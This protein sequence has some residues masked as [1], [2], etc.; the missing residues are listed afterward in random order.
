VSKI[1]FGE[2]ALVVMVLALAGNAVAQ[3]TIKIEGSFFSGIGSPHIESSEDGL[4]RVLGSSD[5]QIGSFGF[6]H[7]QI[8]GDEEFSLDA[9]LSSGDPIAGKVVLITDK[10]SSFFNG[11][12][13]TANPSSSPPK[14]IQAGGMFNGKNGGTS[15]ILATVWH[16]TNP[17]QFLSELNAH[18]GNDYSVF[19]RDDFRFIFSVIMTPQYTATSAID[20]S[21]Q[22][23]GTINAAAAGQLSATIG[24]GASNTQTV[25]L[26]GNNVIGYQWYMVCWENGVPVRPLIDD[27]QA[28]LKPARPKDC[29]SLDQSKQQSNK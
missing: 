27:F 9:A 2:F 26:I 14:P 22:L 8:N 17:Q 18:F 12:V 25:T 23:S 15:T 13:G 1:K 5:A 6:V 11:K 20:F 24:G 7:D 29:L 10:Q 28:K 21:T 16:M 19:G 3:E 4:Y